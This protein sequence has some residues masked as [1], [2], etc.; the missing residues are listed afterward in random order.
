M[1]KYI[2]GP[3]NAVRLEGTIYGN[4][5]IIYIYMDQHVNVLQQTECS[6]L[7]N[8]FNNYI[9]NEMGKI[10]N[11][12]IDFF[13]EI[14]RTSI[15]NDIYK[16]R[17]RYIDEIGKFFIKT[18][19]IKEGKNIGTRYGPNIRFHWIDIRDYFKSQINLYLDTII[20]IIINIRCDMR[21]KIDTIEELHNTLLKLNEK[22]L[23]IIN[24]FDKK[25]TNMRGGTKPIN[26]EDDIN[27]NIINIM[28]KINNKYTHPDLYKK[29]HIIYKIIIKSFM[30]IIEQINNLLVIISDFILYIKKFMKD[31]DHLNSLNK[32]KDGH[33][34]YG[35]DYINN[36]EVINTL[37][38]KIIKLDDAITIA[39]SLLVDMFFLRRFLDKDYIKNAIV[40]TGIA[41]SIQY[42]YIL[43]KEFDMTITHASYLKYDINKTT[44]IIK[45][46]TEINNTINELFYPPKLIQCTDI[47]NFPENFE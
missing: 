16:Y 14:G 1:N 46:S 35:I 45:N 34:T 40:Y 26:Y 24:L 25:I 43:I 22:I 39:F 20:S 15:Y 27:K 12:T 29:L 44:N 9:N 7:S 2:N 30:S 33:L 13:L 6:E 21:I 28:T 19:Q 4:K 32:T 42:I 23:F 38:I 41:H 31:K 3:I 17:N 36:I 10:T 5:K 47:T 11:R 37:Y 18:I 8:D